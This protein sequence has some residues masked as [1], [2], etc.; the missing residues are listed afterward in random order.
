MSGGSPADSTAPTI[1]SVSVAANNSTATVTFSEAV[2]DTNGGSG[3]L[4]AADFA[5]SL[6]G[7]NASSINLNATPS[8]ISKTSQTVWV[9]TLN[10]TNLGSNANGNESLVVDSASDTSIYDAAG[11]A[12]TAA[13]SAVSLNDT[14][15]PKSQTPT[16]SGGIGRFVSP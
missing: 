12:H 3:D 1:S 11:N 10:G 4:E 16:P 6:S 2:Y 9:L 5:L 7:G 15:A 8:G 14:T 13:A